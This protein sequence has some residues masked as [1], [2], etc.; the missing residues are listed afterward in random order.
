MQ[1]TLAVAPGAEAAAGPLAGA[2]TAL[3]SAGWQCLQPAPA[4]EAALRRDLAGSTVLHL[5]ADANAVG[6]SYVTLRLAD[7]A[8]GMRSVNVQAL[9]ALLRQ[10]SPALQ[11]LVLQPASAAE[12]ARAP[13]GLAAQALLRAGVGVL[14]SMHAPTAAAC[15]AFYRSLAA[16][17]R[18]DDAVAAAN[19]AALGTV[20]TVHAGGPQRLQPPPAAAPSAATIRAEPAEAPQP[21]AADPFAA[22]LRLKREAGRFDVFLCHNSADKAAVKRLGEGLKSRGILPWLD[23]W[24]LPPG[25]AWQELLERQIQRI[26]SAAVCL[27]PAGISPWH[28]QEMRGFIS[29]FVDRRVPVIP[30]LLPGAPAKP[31]L[32]LF[33]RQ[34]TWVDFRRDDPDP[35]DQL[36]WGITGRRPGSP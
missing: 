24:E 13:L 28:Q 29:E 1:L 7:S 15:A 9:A 35:F 12:A 3:R 32:P 16:G 36:V 22:A 11:L 17:D 14:V 27:G 19:A 25:Q 8:G 21:V 30:V 5:V 18:V 4:S 23:E 34:F 31:E 10:A 20:A 2:L 6:S 26:G 33:L